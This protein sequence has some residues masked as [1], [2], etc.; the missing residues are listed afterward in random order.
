MEHIRIRYSG[1]VS[2]DKRNITRIKIYF[3]P[4][5]TVIIYAQ[6]FLEAA[7]YS[8]KIDAANPLNITEKTHTI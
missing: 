7:Y 2:G 1:S 3:Q 6:I 5:K 4:L 8:R